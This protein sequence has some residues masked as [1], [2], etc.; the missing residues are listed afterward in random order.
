[1]PVAVPGR[2]TAPTRPRGQPRWPPPP[3]RPP[4]VPPGLDFDDPAVGRAVDGRERPVGGIMSRMST[5][6]RIHLLGGLRVAGFD[7]SDLGSRKARTLLKVLAV[8]EGRPVRADALVE[9]LW[10]DEPPQ[11]PTEQVGVLVSRLRGVLGGDRILRTDA[12]YSLV[13]DWLDL[14][15]LRARVREATTALATGR[16]AAARA[17]STA[18]IALGVGELLPEDEGA[19]VEAARTEAAALATAARRAAVDAS[20]AAGDS[21]TVV[22]EAEGALAHDPYD[23]HMTAQLMRAHVAHGRTG[24]AL[25]AYARL[26]E[27]LLEDL[28]V[29]P[30]EELEALHT[31][32]LVGEQ[33][34]SPSRPERVSGLVGRDAE[35]RQLDE[36]LAS[37]EEGQTVLASIEGEPGIGKTALANEWVGRLDPAA[38]LILRARCEELGRELPLQPIADAYARSA[39]LGSDDALADADR[40]ILASALGI[41][42]AV[43]RS[44]HVDPQIGSARLFGALL[45]GFESV[46]GGRPIVLWVDDLHLA[47]RST[48]E[49]IAFAARRGSRLF[50]LATRRSGAVA[51]PG[52]LTIP[53]GPLSVDAVAVLV[54]EDRARE[55]HRHSGGNPLLATALA[56]ADP[57]E[58]LATVREVVQRQVAALGEAGE[59]LPT[60]A[61]LGRVVDLDLLAGVLGRP[62]VDVLGDLERAVTIGLLVDDG[63]V[64]SFRH[65]LV[66]E[67]LADSLGAA[68]RAFVHREAARS[69]TRRLAAD[70][71][72]VARHARLGGD[73][74]LAASAFLDAAR[75]AQRRYDL[76]AA[77]AYA[78]SAVEL[79][80]GPEP[81]SVR[82]RIRMTRLRHEDAAADAAVAVQGGGSADALEVAAWAAYYRRRYDEAQSLADEAVAAAVDV[83][84]RTS[85]LAVA[86]RVRHARGDLRGARRVLEEVTEDARP[87]VRAVAD[88]WH[89]HVLVHA[90]E[91]DAALRRAEHALAAGDHLAQPFAPLYARFAR[92][93]ALGQ[94]GRPAEALALASELSDVA[95][96]FGTVGQRFGGPSANVTAWVNRLLG[97]HRLA[98]DENQRAIDLTSGAAGPASAVFAEAHWVAWLDLADGAVMTGDIDG[99]AELLERLEGMA[100]WNGNM[101]WHQRHRL[102][103]IRARHALATGDRDTARPLIREVIRDAEERGAGRYLAI[104]RTVALA[105]GD[106]H[107]D[108]DGVLAALDRRAGSEAWRIIAEAARHRGSDALRRCAEGRAATLVRSL[109]QEGDD[110]AQWA[111]T[112]LAGVKG[113]SPGRR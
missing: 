101:A 43:D 77:E 45:R 3:T 29:S 59:A 102:G 108:V 1:M 62:A 70:P 87:D 69:L 64:L 104:A 39:H 88:V 32:I 89:A 109:G 49:W 23:E 74:E 55:L 67:A 107:D 46:A 8:A 40:A 34:P 6:L 56:K 5:G 57:D 11:R 53:L 83:S 36:L 31:R 37:V 35:L 106:P 54:G 72:A 14:I 96:S 41:G 105:F 82:A 25:A 22:A 68:R 50:L 73:R 63:S 4:P 21:A 111:D 52:S 66:R 71:V 27:R 7:D 61:E 79:Q 75:T 84:L 86:G 18:A 65:E 92:V 44:P 24:S 112:V 28:G 19:W 91:P 38:Q 2:G 78:D 85:A 58:A 47:G 13:F 33:E 15:E 30:S 51:L 95:E 48:L 12:G 9:A 94:L 76:T 10:G 17:A 80:D 98:A 110:L 26:R 113:P 103:L 60:A 99:A 42:A 20:A 81:R 16:V 100:S 97:R 90:G 93:L